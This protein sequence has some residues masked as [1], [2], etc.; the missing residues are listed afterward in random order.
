MHCL[1]VIVKRNAEAA[2]RA[3]GHAHNDENAD[4]V[5]KINRA[6]IERD[7]DAESKA[8]IRGY[9]AGRQEG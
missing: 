7:S 8:W 9:R 1:E 4:L 2:G 5:S 3:A 6:E